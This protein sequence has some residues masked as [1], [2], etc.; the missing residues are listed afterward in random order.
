MCHAPDYENLV[1]RG[2][3]YYINQCKEQIAKLDDDMTI[4]NTDQRMKWEAMITSMEAVIVMAH[5][6]ADLAEELAKVCSDQEQ[7]KMYETCLLYTSNPHCGSGE[8]CIDVASP[9]NINRKLAVIL[10]F[11]SNISI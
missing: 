9:G 2:Y 5:R 1:K 11:H 7:K 4:E 3:R 10:C 6:Y 8:N